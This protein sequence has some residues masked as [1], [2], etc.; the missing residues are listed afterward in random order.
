MFDGSDNV[1]MVSIS[2]NQYGA[3]AVLKEVDS[4]TERLIQE[5]NTEKSEYN[6]SNLCKFFHFIDV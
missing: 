2:K 6:K 5:N 3:E 1:N 4:F